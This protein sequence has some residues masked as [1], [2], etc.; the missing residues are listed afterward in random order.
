MKTTVSATSKRGFTL[1]EMVVALT[2]V[3]ILLSLA[4]P[5]MKALKDQEE[6]THITGLLELSQQLRVRAVSERRPYQIVFDHQA[7]YGLRYF[8]PY[9]EETTFQ[10]FLTKQDEE[11]ERRK[12]EIK[13]I[14][15][16]RLQLAEEDLGEMEGAPPPKLPMSTMSTLSGR[17][18]FLRDCVWR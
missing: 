14:V 2:I 15:V 16:Q 1:V 7:I 13:R 4:F 17:S 10:E 9:Q 8:Y 3:A 5:A 18:T 6:P 12:A 11:R